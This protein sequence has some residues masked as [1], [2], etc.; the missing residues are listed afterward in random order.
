[1]REEIQGKLKGGN[2]IKI[3]S[4]GQEITKNGRNRELISRKE[5]PHDFGRRGFLQGHWEEE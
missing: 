1:M 5:R 4:S 2:S 3:L